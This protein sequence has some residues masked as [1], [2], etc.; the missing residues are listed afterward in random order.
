MKAKKQFFTSALVALPLIASAQVVPSGVDS[1]PVPSYDYPAT[2]PWEISAP[3]M[4]AAIQADQNAWTQAQNAGQDHLNS[5]EQAGA[6]NAQ[7][8]VAS[9]TSAAGASLTPA[10]QNDQSQ[11]SY[12]GARIWVPY[13]YTYSCGTEDKPETCTGYSEYYDA[14]AAAQAAY[15]QDQASKNAGEQAAMGGDASATQALAAQSQNQSDQSLAQSNAEMD[16]ASG[17]ANDATAATNAANSGAQAEADAIAQH[18]A[19]NQIA[20]IDAATHGAL[21]R[22]TISP[23][24]APINPPVISAE[25]LSAAGSS[26]QAT[27]DGLAQQN[28]AATQKTAEDYE[29]QQKAQSAANAAAVKAAQYQAKADSAPTAESRAAWLAAAA[30]AKATAIQQQQI[31]DQ[32]K[33]ANLADQQKQNATAAAGVAQAPVTASAYNTNAERLGIAAAQATLQQI[34]SATGVYMQGA[35]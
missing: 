34:E 6:A 9:G 20:A 4:N 5:Q 26:E 7:G 31:A 1:A 27:Q 33:A 14:H 32:Y 13:T 15:W 24:P 30:N 10:I 25:E 22:V 12:W 23:Q 3:D 8:S 2:T 21:T 18:N 29:A 11:A 28:Y 16:A 35:H 19:S 17:D